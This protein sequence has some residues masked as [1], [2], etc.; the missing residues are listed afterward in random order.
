MRRI[1]LPSTA[2][3]EHF[4]PRT[5]C[6]EESLRLSNGVR[7]GGSFKRVTHGLYIVLAIHVAV[8][9]FY[10]YMP[11]LL[12]PS[13]SSYFQQYIEEASNARTRNKAEHSGMQ[14]VGDIVYRQDPG[15][16][17]VL[18]KERKGNTHTTHRQ[19]A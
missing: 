9:I 12:L 4:R 10:L 2:R 3:R 16:A 7:I 6:D 17:P 19:H 13:E 15:R 18:R 14:H 8:Y 5:T 1:H 11:T